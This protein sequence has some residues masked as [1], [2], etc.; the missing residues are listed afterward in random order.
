MKH[1]EIEDAHH[2][3]NT[4]ANEI[5]HYV[6][7]AVTLVE[8]I[9]NPERGAP[10]RPEDA[11][12]QGS[13]MYSLIRAVAFMDEWEELGNLV[14]KGIEKD[15]LLK[16]R[17]VAKPMLSKVRELFPD[18]REYRTILAHNARA[19][20]GENTTNAFRGDYLSK[21]VVPVSLPDYI[22]ISNCLKICKELFN[23]A[24]PKYNIL[25]SEFI[26]KNTVLNLRKGLTRA[27][28]DQVVTDL[29]KQLEENL[30]NYKAK[31]DLV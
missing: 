23:K 17:R 28:Q 24:F 14:S 25:P 31:E 29:I 22:L 12:M 9:G 7:T 11:L 20:K 16:L 6:M 2:L 13:L 10:I 21:L 30:A 27:E 18:L 4:T 19:N 1:I 15:R 8:K 3:L 26:A 5:E